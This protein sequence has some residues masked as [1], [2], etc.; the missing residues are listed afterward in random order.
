[1]KLGND[2]INLATEIA[3]KAAV[4]LEGKSPSSIAAVS[5]L[6]ATKLQGEKRWEK[7]IAVAAS[8][9]P[10]TIRNVFKELLPHQE[11]ILPE[12]H[13]LLQNAP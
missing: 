7:D 11:S 6:A 9:S 3:N 8:I 2:I 4:F 5:I 10:T 1:M 12:G 13:R